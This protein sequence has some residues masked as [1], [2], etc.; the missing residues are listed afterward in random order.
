MLFSYPEL[1]FDRGAIGENSSSPGIILHIPAHHLCHIPHFLI[2]SIAANN[3]DLLSL[4]VNQAKMQLD[5]PA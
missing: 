5:W 1:A 2:Y 3:L 4:L